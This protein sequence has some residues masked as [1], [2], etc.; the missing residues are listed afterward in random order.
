MSATYNPKAF[1]VADKNAAMGIILTP[2]GST[3]ELRWKIE[4]PYVA[5]LIGQTINITSSTIILDYGCG[6]GRMAKE[7]ID[8][9]QCCV[10]GV[11]IS[12]KMLELAHQYVQ[13]DRFLGCSPL[14]LDTLTESGLRFDAAIS[15]WVLQHC[16]KP[17]EDIS[18][19]QRSLRPNAGVF[20]LNNKWRA[21]P[22]VEKAWANDGIDIKTSLAE[23]FMLIH[24]GRLPPDK[25]T[26]SLSNIHFWAVFE[27]ENPSKTA[28]Q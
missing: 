21:V 5:D 1:D 25:T 15:I 18:R 13:S 20:V 23:H 28:A 9:H 10:I 7:L 19:I 12:P 27:N 26:N 24:E 8:R 4:T 17:D 11:D 14:M 22:T 6:I 2:E 16:L 3:T